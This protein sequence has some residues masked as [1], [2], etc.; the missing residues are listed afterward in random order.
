MTEEGQGNVRKESAQTA[1]PAAPKKKGRPP[2]PPQPYP[3]STFSLAKA[4][5]TEVAPDDLDIED[6]TF[7]CRVVLKPEALFDSVRTHGIQMPL[8]VRKH[9]R[10]KDR[11]QLV[12]GFRRASAAK[13]VGLAKVPVVVR[14]LTDEEAHILSYT[15]NENRRTLNDLDRAHAIVKLQSAGKD[16]AKIAQLYRLGERQVQRLREL[17]DYP[18][19]LRKAIAEVETTGV[20]TTHAMLLMAAARKY[21]ARFDL[22]EWLVGVRKMKMSVE[23]LRRELRTEFGGRRGPRRAWRRTGDIFSFDLKKLKDAPDAERGRVISELQK[24]LKE[25][26]G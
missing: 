3:G 7:Q 17:V 21:R 1:T 5:V 18:A 4:Q 24:L 11:Y 2:K 14:D 13:A 8:V 12:C 20:T 16:T 10:K 22:K 6:T 19:E 26:K 9:P 15:E 25:L 23:D